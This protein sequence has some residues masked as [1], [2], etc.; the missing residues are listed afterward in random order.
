MKFRSEVINAGSTTV[1][2]VFE[3]SCTKASPMFPASSRTRSKAWV[4]V[5][6]LEEVWSGVVRAVSL[7]R[8]HSGWSSHRGAAERFPASRSVS[9]PR[10]S[11][12]SPSGTHR[13][14]PFT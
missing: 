9:T 14:L 4:L 10:R 12:R 8:M 6:L 7:F 11:D 3:S 13:F 1:F 2:A 5:E